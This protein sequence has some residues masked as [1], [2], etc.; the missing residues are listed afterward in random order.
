MNRLH[1]ASTVALVS[2]LA[3]LFSAHPLF[4]LTLILSSMVVGWAGMEA[5]FGDAAEV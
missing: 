1:Y 5:R 2:A 4:L 3:L